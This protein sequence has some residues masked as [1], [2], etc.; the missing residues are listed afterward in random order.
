MSSL[1]CC[2]LNVFHSADFL[3]DSKEMQGHHLLF[4]HF[5]FWASI[6]DKSEEERFLGVIAGRV[7]RYGKMFWDKLAGYNSA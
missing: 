4:L 1:P 5:R 6:G 7:E 2:Y 3:F